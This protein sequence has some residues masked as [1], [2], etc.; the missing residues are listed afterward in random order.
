MSNDYIPVKELEFY[1]WQR[2]ALQYAQDNS[3]RFAIA[4][5]VFPPLLLKRDDYEAKYA[6]SE[7]ALTRTSAAILARKESREDYTIDLRAFYKGYVIYNPAVTDSDRRIMGLTVHDKKPT[8]VPLPVH[9]PEV[10]FSAPS[11]GVI[12]I[13][14]RDKNEVG[15]AKPYGIHGAEVAWGV[16]DERPVDWSELPRSSFATHSP[17]RLSFNGHDRGKHFFFAARWEN[18]GGEKGPWTEILETLVP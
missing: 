1:Q 16:L 9:E 10:T 6:V 3:E 12:E 2:P 18:N 14:F 7:N 15:N 4:Q 13:H 11:P 17:M 5:T 8:P